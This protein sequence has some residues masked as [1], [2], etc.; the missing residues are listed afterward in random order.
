MGYLHDTCDHAACRCDGVACAWARY[1]RNVSGRVFVGPLPRMVVP[2]ATTKA[3]SFVV[4]RIATPGFGQY[5]VY[6]ENRAGVRVPAGPM[7]TDSSDRCFEEY[8]RYARF[9]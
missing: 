1:H 7:T 6:C 5:M 3:W 9:M 4:E 8:E 2:F